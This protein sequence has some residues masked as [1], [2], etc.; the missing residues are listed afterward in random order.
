MWYWE[1]IYT[2][3]NSHDKKLSK[4][5]VVSLVFSNDTHHLPKNIH[6]A[7]KAAAGNSDLQVE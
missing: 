1:G 7:V 3:R 5:A 6:I 2:L 4:A